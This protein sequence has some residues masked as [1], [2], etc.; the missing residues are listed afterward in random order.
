MRHR[1][2]LLLWIAA[3]LASSLSIGV[4]SWVLLGP[5]QASVQEFRVTLT[6]GTTIVA[7]VAPGV[8]KESL[9]QPPEPDQTAGPL[10][11]QS[12]AAIDGPTYQAPLT[13]Q[14]PERE[15]VSL[16]NAALGG[17]GMFMF[18]AL[19]ITYLRV[20]T[21]RSSRRADSG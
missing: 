1:K 3:A 17:V 14:H 7:V 21:G 13:Y 15:A 8:S 19:A 20:R 9:T 10:W 18:F 11:G 4:A 2:A 6:N 12:V 5:Y 16:R